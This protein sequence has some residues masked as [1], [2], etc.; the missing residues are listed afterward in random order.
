MDRII[1][2]EKIDVQVFS[3]LPLS[4]RMEVLTQGKTLYVQNDVTL[5]DIIKS[6][7]ISYM[8]LEPMRNRFKR[9]ILGTY[10]GT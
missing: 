9:R 7:V 5:R 8:D 2:L 1:F 6:V 10:N 4:A 3:D